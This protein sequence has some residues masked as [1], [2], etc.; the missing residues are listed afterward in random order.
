MP[1]LNFKK[2]RE[3]K[4]LY[5]KGQESTLKTRL[6]I[7]QMAKTEAGG[8]EIQRILWKIN[9]TFVLGLCMCTGTCKSTRMLQMYVGQKYQCAQHL[10]PALKYF[11][12][13]TFELEKKKKTQN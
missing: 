5:F 4:R 12:P 10:P 11:H 2:E 13:Q 1:N 6:V 9:S 8:S 7:W 3:R